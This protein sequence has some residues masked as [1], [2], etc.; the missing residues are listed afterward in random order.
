MS[1]FAVSLVLAHLHLRASDGR[2]LSDIKNADNGSTASEAT[3]LTTSAET[4][5]RPHGVGKCGPA[6][7]G[8]KADG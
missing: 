3:R 2:S 8:V 4:N 7:D 6:G 5:D 1:I